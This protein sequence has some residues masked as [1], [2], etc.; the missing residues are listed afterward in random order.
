MYKCS[1][2]GRVG[3]WAVETETLSGHAQ[4]SDGAGATLSPCC[5]APVEEVTS[6][7]IPV[8]GETPEETFDRK[9]CERFRYFLYNEFTARERSRLAALYGCPLLEHPDDVRY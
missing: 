8:E 4:M 6:K 3:E 7:T 2:C 1:N 9:L 5:G